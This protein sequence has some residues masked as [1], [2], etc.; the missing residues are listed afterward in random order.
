MTT[1]KSPPDN[2]VGN[3]ASPHGAGYELSFELAA[4]VARLRIT[5]EL[6][7]SASAA[8]ED[9]MWLAGPLTGTLEIDAGGVTAV[10][11]GSIGRLMT[12][13][14]ARA[15]G[16]LPVVVLTAISGSMTASLERE[17]LI[18]RSPLLLVR[19]APTLVGNPSE[20]A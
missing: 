4:G 17:G 13:S 8:I 12:A 14:A 9:L 10:A 1:L 11:R 19:P 20:P 3:S 15:W 7:E 2:A 18:V 5:G 6:N 16:G